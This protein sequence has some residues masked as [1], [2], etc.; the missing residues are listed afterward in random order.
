MPTPTLKELVEQIQD[1]DLA[2]MVRTQE[3]LDSLTKPLGSLGRLEEIAKQVA[4]ISRDPRPKIRWKTIF[5][6]AADHGVARY[7]VSAYPPEVTRQMVLN[8][9]NGGAGINVLARQAGAQIVVADFGVAADMS[10]LSGLAHCKVRLGTD[11]IAH[12]PAMSEAEALKA[13]AAGAELVQK[14]LRAGVGLIGTGDMGIGNTT[15]SSALAAVFTG[16]P[17]T[18]VTGRGTG[19]DDAAFRH[20]VQVIAQALAI[21]APDASRPLQALAKVGGFEIAGLVGVILAG[22]SLGIPVLIDGF[23]SGAAA[24]VACRLAPK[25]RS[26][27][28]A[29]HQ[30]VEKG[31]AHVLKHLELEPLLN[32]RLRL[33]EGTGA[34]LAMPIVEAA[35]KILDEMA[36]FAQAGVSERSAPVEPATR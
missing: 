2:L 4:G 30:S 25:T 9:L 7:G 36:T 35:C 8:F 6:L 16:L 22:A 20:K 15:P 33:G 13:I 31:H 32:L 34:A 21:N 26:Y 27:L 1:V 17:P 5:T 19:I 14:N 23:I 10:A 18:E 3:R 24:L 11:S 29:S 28:I 12:G